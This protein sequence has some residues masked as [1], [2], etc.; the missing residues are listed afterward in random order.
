MPYK[1]IKTY[2]ERIL[3]FSHGLAVIS[4]NVINFL[5]EMATTIKAWYSRQPF[6]LNKQL[7][8]FTE[9]LG[10]VPV[11]SLHCSYEYERIPD[12]V[13][14][15]LSCILSATSYCIQFLSVCESW[16]TIKECND[17]WCESWKWPASSWLG[18]FHPKPTCFSTPL[19]IPA[20]PSKLF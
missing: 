6:G 5:L 20:F 14:P 11:V 9:M 2:L 7:Y 3:L 17:L 18:S 10:L 19:G 15:W 13:C 4:W 1:W 8:W 16:L 12:T